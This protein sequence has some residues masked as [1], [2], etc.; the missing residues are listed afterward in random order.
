[1]QPLTAPVRDPLTAQQVAGILSA[2]SLKVQAG[3]DRLNFNLQFQEDISSRLTAG[4]V[5]RAMYAVIHGTCTLSFDKDYAWG[6]DLFRPYMILSDANNPSLAARFDMGVF[7]LAT[8]KQDAATNERVCTGYDR[9]Y[10]LNR[11]IG[12]TYVVTAG[13]SYLVAMQAVVAAAGLVGVLLDGSATG[14]TLPKD[15]VWPLIPPEAGSAQDTTYLQVFNDLADSIGYRHCWCDEQGLFRSEPNVIPSVRGS[16]YTFDATTTRTLVGRR[17]SMASDI[18][19]VPNKWVFVQQNRA[20]TPTLANGGIYI[21]SNQSSGPASIDNRQLT[22]TK[23]TRLNAADSAALATQGDLIV[24][25]D[26]AVVTTYSVTTGPFPPAG[27]FDVFAYTDPALF[28]GT[29][30]VVAT[31][32]EQNLAGSDVNWTWEST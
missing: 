10:F 1:M 14:K 22:W 23:T 17:R 12:D 7:S 19:A 29:R 32:W 27:H 6:L 15:M 4:A 11:S 30:K 26:K 13:T 21:V 8:P 31:K 20:D 25:K 16:E 28:S 2:R 9:L 24:A 18:W 3:C 5:G